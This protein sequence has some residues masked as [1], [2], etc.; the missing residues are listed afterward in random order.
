MRALI[1]GVTGMDGSHL[2]EILVEQGHDVFGVI[3]DPDRRSANLDNWTLAA[4]VRYVVADLLDAE[5]LRRA[6]V[7]AQPDAIYHLAAMSSPSQAWV[8]PELCG[9]VTGIAV[10]RLLDVAANVVPGAAVIVAGSLATHGP[11]GAAKEY[12]RLIAADHRARGQNVTTIV[13]GGHHSP[14]RGASYLSQKVARHAA[15]AAEAW[16]HDG[17]AVPSK[18]HLGWLGRVQDWGW[19]PDFMRTWSSAHLLA[20]GEYVLSTGVPYA[21]QDYVA[22]AYES[23]GLRWLD[24][25]IAGTGAAQPVDV[26]TLTAKPDPALDFIPTVDFADLVSRMVYPRER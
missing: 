21:V 15:A 17:G 23:A 19:A 1:T 22:S 20:P 13:M 10:G 8:M 14:R 24:W 7:Q 6:F 16:R 2:A 12:A 18:L 26:A 25:V 3:R 4:D 11:Y 5:S 9:Q